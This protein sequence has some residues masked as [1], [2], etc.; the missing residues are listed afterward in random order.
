MAATTISIT[1]NRPK[2]RPWDA[3]SRPSSTGIRNPITATRRAVSTEPSAD[4]SAERFATISSRKNTARGIRL[5]S[6]VARRLSAM[7]CTSGVYEASTV[8]GGAV[9]TK[10]LLVE[11][12]G[13]GRTGT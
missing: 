12:Y 13:A 6:A 5:T 9:A 8:A 4:T 3:E 10:L 1:G 7:A 2:S 11:W